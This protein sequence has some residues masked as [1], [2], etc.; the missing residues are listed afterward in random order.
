MAE[1]A[2]NLQQPTKKKKKK[3]K[4]KGKAAKKKI[5]QEVRLEKARKWLASYSGDDVVKAYRKKFA[6]ER[7]QT[8]SELQ[9]LGVTITDEQ[10]A[11]EKRAVEARIQQEKAKKA[12]RRAK[13][14]AAKAAKAD[15]P[16]FHTDQD[17]RF[18]FIAGYTS[19]GAPYGVTWDEM[20][21]EPWE[22]IEDL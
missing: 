6:T 19:G 21:L 14:K 20:G 17:D 10:I 2:L 18:F 7:M 5:P 22:S 15:T 13:R 3:K 8:V 16:M 9:L 1:E 11:R 12:K 4:L